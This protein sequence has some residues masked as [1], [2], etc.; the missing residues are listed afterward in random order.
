MALSWEHIENDQQFNYRRMCSIV[1]SISK[2]DIE[3]YSE[4]LFFLMTSEHAPLIDRDMLSQ[5]DEIEEAL[6][7]DENSIERLLTWLDG[8]IAKSDESSLHR[9]RHGYAVSCLLRYRMLEALEGIEEGLSADDVIRRINF[10]K[11]EKVLTEPRGY[12]V[13]TDKEASSLGNYIKTKVS[14]VLSVMDSID[15]ITHFHDRGELANL[16]SNPD[17]PYCWELYRNIGRWGIGFLSSLISDLLNLVKIADE[18]YL[19]SNVLCSLHPPV[20]FTFLS[21]RE[22]GEK[23]LLALLPCPSDF[24]SSAAAYILIQRL[25]EMNQKHEGDAREISGKLQYERDGAEELL[26]RLE[27][28]YEKTHRSYRDICK[29]IGEVVSAWAVDRAELIFNMLNKL[30]L[31][32]ELQREILETIVKKDDL[33]EKTVMYGIETNDERMKWEVLWNLV[34]TAE[35]YDKSELADRIFEYGAWNWLLKMEKEDSYI[36]EEERLLALNGLIRL[37]KNHHDDRFDRYLCKT[38]EK[39]VNA[40]MDRYKSSLQT[41]AHKTVMMLNA[42]MHASNGVFEKAKRDEVWRGLTELITKLVNLD[43][44]YTANDVL[45]HQ[46]A[47]NLIGSFETDEE[48][49]VILQMCRSAIYSTRYCHLWVHWLPDD[50]VKKDKIIK[51]LLSDLVET[52]PFLLGTLSENDAEF[53]PLISLFLDSKNVVLETSAL[54]RLAGKKKSKLGAI[55]QSVLDAKDEQYIIRLVQKVFAMPLRHPHFRNLRQVLMNVLEKRYPLAPWKEEWKKISWV[56]RIEKLKI[57]G[58]DEALMQR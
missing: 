25:A 19:I 29:R 17:L 11:R 5:K 57:C 54:G 23:T 46:L 32:E 50:A 3:P 26:D 13:L 7:L 8:L 58:F 33:F 10:E 21:S 37:L 42:Y 9:S 49:M 22:V 36:S 24:A 31:P 4:T 2:S 34:L 38:Q 30:R 1:R 39:L 27:Q 40:S 55:C 51:G 14:G 15:M 53:F 28:E 6:G 41:F 44:P 20:L 56:G 16:F 12:V 43:C 18:D 52:A 35:E 47:K 48:Y 45:F